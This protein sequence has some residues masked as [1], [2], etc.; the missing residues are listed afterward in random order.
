MSSS[1][2][3]GYPEAAL[4]AIASS[5]VARRAPQRRPGGGSSNSPGYEFLPHRDQSSA[6]AKPPLRLGVFA[7]P[8]VPGTCGFVHAEAPAAV[9]RSA[10]EDLAL[11]R[12]GE[13]PLATLQAVRQPGQA[14]AVH[15]TLAVWLP[16]LGRLPRHLLRQ[17]AERVAVEVGLTEAVQVL[18]RARSVRAAGG[19]TLAGGTVAHE[20]RAAPAGASSAGRAAIPATAAVVVVGARVDADPTAARLPRGAGAQAVDASLAVTALLPALAAVAGIGLDVRAHLA[21]AAPARPVRRGAGAA[22][23]RAGLVRDA[24]VLAHAAVPRVRLHVHAGGGARDGACVGLRRRAHAR[25][26]HALLVRKRAGEAAA[27]AIPR[28]SRDVDALGRG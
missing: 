27:A 10:L 16:R 23:V 25:A 1:L 6:G 2:E 12:T 13:A 26:V 28:V 7:R 5:L 24:L 18:E 14:L 17:A 9:Q 11:Q 15:L 22:S 21:L 4:R 8:L 19:P 3:P 20:R